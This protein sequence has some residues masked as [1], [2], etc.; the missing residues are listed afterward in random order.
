MIRSAEM[1]RNQARLDTIDDLAR[2][3]TAADFGA[4][5]R[6]GLDSAERVMK[7]R[8]SQLYGEVDPEGVLRVN[9]QKAID[10][11][12]AA[13]SNRFSVAVTPELKQLAD[14]MRD[15]GRP[16]TWDEVDHAMK[17][18]GNIAGKAKMEGDNATKALALQMKSALEDTLDEIDDA[19]LQA[20][21]A[22]HRE[23]RGLLGR[24]QT[25]S[26]AI[27][28]VLDR[29]RFNAPLVPNEKSADA[30]ISSPSGVRQFLG[31]YEKALRDAT[32]DATQAAV[33][34]NLDDA[35]E[36]L[37]GQFI[38]RWRQNATTTAP[39]LDATGEIVDTLS[40]PKA[41]SWWRRNAETAKLLFSPDEFQRL[42]Q[43][44]ADFTESNLAAIANARG[45]PTAQNLAV[46]NL[47]SRTTGG[48]VN[49][50]SPGGSLLLGLGGVVPRVLHR[51]VEEKLRRELAA[52]LLDPRYARGLISQLDPG[53][54]ARAGRYRQDGAIKKLMQDA[55]LIRHPVR[56]GVGTMSS[57][58]RGE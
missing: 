56:T 4:R 41:L 50:Q 16:M 21:R 5:V 33:R 11:F 20:A 45:S 51:S 55:L 54:I 49:P 3:G 48:F 1:A 38:D 37:R 58:N 57:V 43:L 35:L 6:T 31:V 13:A 26:N 28:R 47:I 2:T 17:K 29:D 46:Q 32:D 22:Q 25:G 40:A 39:S 18:L 42:E 15:L 34:A 8:T 36:G 14:E 52:A 44:A 23:V 53:A 7:S 27:G 9:P 30:I 10:T 19:A 24:D 12:D